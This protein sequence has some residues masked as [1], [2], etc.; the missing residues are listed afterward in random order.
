MTTLTGQLHCRDASGL[1]VPFGAA[2]RAVF[3]DG[4]DPEAFTVLLH[5]SPV[6]DSKPHSSHDP[7]ALPR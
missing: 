6:A 2:V 4:Q 7:Q 5:V 1:S 3:E